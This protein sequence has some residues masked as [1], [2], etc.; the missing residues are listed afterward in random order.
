MTDLKELAKTE[1]V[2]P[3]G[4][5]DFAEVK[6]LTL[7]SYVA[8]F[9]ALGIEG[10]AEILVIKKSN[11][12]AG[13]FAWLNNGGELGESTR[14]PYPNTNKQEDTAFTQNIAL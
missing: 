8:F 7:T 3:K 6:C 2:K 4:D 14:W 11:P 9:E 1:C 12:A 13:Y 10:G 5:Y